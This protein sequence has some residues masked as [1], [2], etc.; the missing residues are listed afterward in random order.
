MTGINYSSG[1]FFVFFI[2]I[3]EKGKREKKGAEGFSHSLACTGESG[4]R[5]GGGRCRWEVMD[6]HC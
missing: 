2:V 1:F 4:F 3:D 5:F 6:L